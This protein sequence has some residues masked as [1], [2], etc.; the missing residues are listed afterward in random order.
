MI[1]EIKKGG[2]YVFCFALLLVLTSS[3][4]LAHSHQAMDIKVVTSDANY[5]LYDYINQSG[6]NWTVPASG[7][8]HDA[9]D[10][11]VM[12]SKDYGT[13]INKH[14][15]LQDFIDREIVSQSN[16]WDDSAKLIWHDASDIRNVSFEGR[17]I[18]LQEWTNR[19][20]PECLSNEQCDG[21]EKGEFCNT[22]TELCVQCLEDS[23]C[24][25]NYNCNNNICEASC[26]IVVEG[27]NTIN[28]NATVS[29]LGNPNGKLGGNSELRY[30]SINSD[31]DSMT[32][33]LNSN[34]G[35]NLGN[36][37][38]FKFIFM[39]NDGNFSNNSDA[40]IINLKDNNF[41]HA[42][43][44]DGSTNWLNANNDGSVLFIQFE[45]VSGTGEIEYG[46]EV[47]LKF[48]TQ[49]DG[50][51]DNYI[52]IDSTS[53]LGFLGGGPHRPLRKVETDDNKAIFKICR[54]DGDCEKKEVGNCDLEDR[55]VK[56]NEITYNQTIS[57]IGKREHTMQDDIL[58]AQGSAWKY[59]SINSEG[60]SMRRGLNVNRNS[61]GNSERFK[62]IPVDESKKILRYGDELKIIS[63]RDGLNEKQKQIR[64]TEMSDFEK[65]A[66]IVAATA[67]GA[68]IGYG[69]GAITPEA[70]ILSGGI[71]ASVGILITQILS[72][73]WLNAN[74]DGYRVIFT[75]EKA[76]NSEGDDVE[77]GEEFYL[78]MK[79]E[80]EAESFYV[81]TKGALNSLPPSYWPL[82]KVYHDDNK[83]TF[84][85]C[86]EDGD[87]WNYKFDEE[88]EAIKPSG[89]YVCP[90][91]KFGACY[92]TC[93]GGDGKDRC[94]YYRG[95]ICTIKHEVNCELV[96]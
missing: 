14:F 28:K 75:I 59:L 72:Y 90:D 78:K 68:G 67:L 11:K 4:I 62:L 30:L 88:G 39:S 32:N 58:R 7:V 15:S 81:G 79:K 19:N 96:A 20:L 54:S 76:G 25:E 47:Y 27:D 80:N 2:V 87:C 70:I 42:P 48:D 29:I 34:R 26:R 55:F 41:I 82:R 56:S 93:D 5:S 3:S 33:G 89:N 57:I 6:I 66:I 13:G 83:M 73:D 1:N 74:G 91:I 16:V 17:T 84:K 86:R 37:E 94:V 31:G 63:E 64:A 52:G 51:Y 46:D 36:S 60:N 49:G 50:S 22:T 38:K 53:I 43:S 24:G 95:T 85:I 21:N 35:G 40:R 9:S 92:S 23:D 10:I 65:G 77:I 12:V 61:V 18:N 8:W 69:S 44:G 45:K 71:G